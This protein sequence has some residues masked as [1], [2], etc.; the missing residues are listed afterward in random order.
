MKDFWYYVPTR[1]NFGPSCFQY[2]SLGL[3]AR[4][5][6]IGIEEEKLPIMAHNASIVGKDY[7]KNAFRT[8]DEKSALE[9]YKLAY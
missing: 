3:P 6:D 9:I 5:R 1:I 8:L 2:P 4:L 7:F